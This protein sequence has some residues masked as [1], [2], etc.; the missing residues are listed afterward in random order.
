MKNFLKNILSQIALFIVKTKIKS[1]PF[2]KISN[3]R[4]IIIAPHPDDEIIGLGGLLLKLK[5]N[6]QSV[7]VVF[8][9]NGE[10]SEASKNKNDIKAARIKMSDDILCKIGI[11]KNHIFRMQLPDGHVPQLGATDFEEVTTQLK[12]IIKT[13]QPTQVFATHPLDYWPFDHVACAH[14]AKQALQDLQS[15]CAL[16]YYWVWAWYHLKPWQVLCMNF[17]NYKKIDVSN[18]LSQKIN[19]IHQYLKPLSPD[20]KPWSGVLPKTLIKCNTQAYELI[21]KIPY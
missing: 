6:H 11:P 21:E 1:L 19:L 15:Q 4:I 12:A 7:Y 16:Y 20:Q 13:I 17:K 14:L 9:T 18:E 3:H 8:L 5:A 10:G 2:Y